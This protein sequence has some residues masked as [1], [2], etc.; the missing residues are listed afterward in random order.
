MNE[1]VKHA[2]I[3]SFLST[4]KDRFHEYNAPKTLPERLQLAAQIDGISGV[5]MVFPYEVTTDPQE[6]K[7][8][9]ATSGL[10]IAAVNV[11]VKAEP[12]FRNCSLTATDPHIRAQAV[13]FIRR[14]KDY[15][16]AVGADKVTCCPLAD[17]DVQLPVRLRPGME[18][19][20]PD[21]R[22]EAATGGRSCSSSN[23]RPARHEAAVSW[24][25]P[26]RR[27]YC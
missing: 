20:H 8:M 24:I 16:K 21:M 27:C 18:A 4:T 9:L 2:V 10:S 14:A 6:M 19:S 15:A 22:E 5:E 26:P 7:Q 3:T 11:N 12:Q 1:S 13:D 25:R 23:T 17:G